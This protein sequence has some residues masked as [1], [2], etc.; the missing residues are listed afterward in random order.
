MYTIITNNPL[1]ESEYSRKTEFLDSGAGDIL[2]RARDYIHSGAKLLGH[3][4]SGGVMPG[5]NPYKSLVIAR[6]AT[7]L[8]ATVDL[9]SLE[10]IE[11]AIRLLKKAP[12]GF[13]GY[14]EKTLED[15][16]ILDLDM[17]VSC[18]KRLML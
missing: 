4:L 11:N 18:V 1:A 3:P 5:V 9:D 2:L 16:M 6:P 15:F 7:G 13:E 10:L 14:D 12:E 8:P 17:L